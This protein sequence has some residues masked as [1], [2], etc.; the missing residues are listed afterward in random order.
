M[1]ELSDHYFDTPLSPVCEFKKIKPSNIPVNFVY[2]IINLISFWESNDVTVGNFFG[3]S[4]ISYIIVNLKK[5]HKQKYKHSVI[6]GN[7]V[8]IFL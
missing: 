6:S 8:Y 7:F 3:Y 5:E 1:M 2:T 4:T